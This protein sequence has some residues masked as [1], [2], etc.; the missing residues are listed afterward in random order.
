[1]TTLRPL[2]DRVLVKRTEEREQKVGSL[3]VPDTAREKP[4]HGEVVAVGAGKILEDGS[5]V[6]PDIRVGDVVLFGKYAGTEVT[7]DGE[8][9]LVLREEELFGVVERASTSKAG[10]V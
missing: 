9:Y 6:P 4:Q 3:Y 7:L 2:R 10:G 5:R 1:M 8:A